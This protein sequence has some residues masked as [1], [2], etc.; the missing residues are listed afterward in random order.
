MIELYTVG[1]GSNLVA[2]LNAVAA[3]VNSAVMEQMMQIAIVGSVIVFGFKAA[4]GAGLGDAGKWAAVVCVVWLGFVENKSTVLVVD[5]TNPFLVGAAVD[6]VPWALAAFAGY[7]SQAGSAISDRYTALTSTPQAVSYQRNG[8]VFGS[9]LL[10]QATR[11]RIVED[12]LSLSLTNFLE[13]CVLYASLLNHVNFEVIANADDLAAAIGGD[14]V[15]SLSYLEFGTDDAGADVTTTVACADGFAGLV[16]RVNEDVER[17]LLKEAVGRYPSPEFTDAVKV[18]RFV[19]DLEGFQNYMIGSAVEA[20]DRIRQM[21]FVTALDDSINRFIASSGNDATMEYY[22]AAR[23]EAQTITSYNAT[24]AGAL[25]WVPLLKAA[26]ETVYVALFPLAAFLLVT[27]LWMVV[28]KG[29]FGGFIWLTS[30]EAISVVLHNIVLAQSSDYYTGAATFVNSAGAR[31]AVMSWANHLG[32]RSVEGDISTVAGYLMSLAPFLAFGIFFGASRMQGLA[33]GFL[34]VGQGAAIEAGREAS[35]GNLSLANTSMDTH[36][37]NSLSTSAMVDRGRA[38]SFLPSGDSATI[39]ADGSSSMAAGSALTTGG[40]GLGLGNQLGESFRLAAQTSQ[41]AVETSAQSVSEGYSAAIR[42]VSSLM[43]RHGSN[44]S[45]GSTTGTSDSVRSSGSLSSALGNV[46]QFAE[47]HG[48][49]Q[50]TAIRAVLDAGLGA[51]AGGSLLSG[52]VG[53]RATGDV[54]GRENEG[55]EALVQ[56]ARSQNLGRDLVSAVES[57]Q[58]ESGSITGSHGYDAQSGVSASL[59]K[60]SSA[61]STHSSAVERAETLS[62][63]AETFSSTSASDNTQLATA[64][65]N[66]LGSEQGMTMS[67]ISPIMN[68]KTTSEVAQS[69]AHVGAFMQH[70]ASEYGIGAEASSA[71]GEGIASSGVSNSGPLGG[72]RGAAAELAVQDGFQTGAMGIEQDA[73]NRGDAPM[74]IDQEYARITRSAGAAQDEVH[75]NM[76]AGEEGLRGNSAAVQ[77]NV[78]EMQEKSTA[79][80][81]MDKAAKA[82]GFK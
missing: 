49:D 16:E 7:S 37:A 23:A 68:P 59:D 21:M 13:Q 55:Y 61:V 40:V 46:Q 28:L 78:E 8:F 11:Y 30:W 18:S 2:M 58:G 22:S 53:A 29:Y 45:V 14:L 51:S 24:G 33:T 42:E 74:D 60:L 39:N 34:N 56:S 79:G 31:E 82:A 62:R 15:S 9:T 5:R 67:E 10:S 52:S 43:D 66:Y 3:F 38:T 47:R 35:T 77:E 72:A 75:G 4:S 80:I 25:K 27:P 17:V 63:A 64:F 69:Q 19:E 50:S 76:S 81:F 32:I 48:V 12:R 6:N 71:F 54:Q 1:G 26:F 44:T 73:I 70:V 41:R 36:S 20:R 65:M 57:N